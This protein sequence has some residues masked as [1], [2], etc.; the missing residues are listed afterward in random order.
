MAKKANKISPE[1]KAFQE[2]LKKVQKQIDASLKREGSRKIMQVGKE[3]AMLLR[4]LQEIC[5]DS[6]LTEEVAEINLAQMLKDYPKELKKV[7]AYYN[8]LKGVSTRKNFIGVTVKP[9]SLEE[10]RLWL[11]CDWHQMELPKD[12]GAVEVQE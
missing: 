12:A 4:W 9:A 1:E 7:L 2:L 6:T 5:G 11:A 3:L 10:G 8:S